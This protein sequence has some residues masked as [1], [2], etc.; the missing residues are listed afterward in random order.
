[1]SDAETLRAQTDDTLAAVDELLAEADAEA[2]SA[3]A[4]IGVEADALALAKLLE[5]RDALEEA[6][7]ARRV[8][9]L[10]A[11]PDGTSPAGALRVSITRPETIDADAFTKD[12][13]PEAEPD[14]YRSAL[15]VAKVRQRYAPEALSGYLKHGRRQVRVI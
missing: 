10:K 4:L 11:L 13:P 6:I 1:V 12:H 7:T 3:D 8:A 5:Q 15:V 14:L 9:L 2:A